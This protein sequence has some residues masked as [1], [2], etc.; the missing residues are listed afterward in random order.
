MSHLSPQALLDHL[1]ALGIQAE[2]VEHEPV[3]TV[4]ES[5]PVKARIPGAHSKNLFVKDK[6]GRLFLITAKDETPIDLKRAH[7]AIGASG[8]LSFGSAE[9]L[10][11]VLGVEPG[12]VTPFAIVNDRAGQ[13]TM[14]LDANLMEHERVNFHPL[15]NSMTTGVSR[16]DL[17]RF[18]RST[19]H[20]PVILR[21]PEPSQELPDGSAAPI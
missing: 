17:L 21:L 12:S 11:S 16:E 3:F 19:G 20:E 15:V 4:A 14:I 10:R 18:I 9:Q 2:T 1:A 8:R 13:V 5:R 6:K 7:E